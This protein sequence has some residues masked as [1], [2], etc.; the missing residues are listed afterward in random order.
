MY[1]P[2]LLFRGLSNHQYDL[3]PGLDRYPSPTW[4]N[5]LQTVEKD[6]VQT[7]QQKYPLL[8]PDTD[9]PVI[10]LAKLQHYGI[11]TRMMDVTENALV[12]LY[13]ACRRNTQMDG[14][15]IAFSGVLRSAYDPT[16]NIVADTYR[17]TGNAYT[18]VKNYRFRAL[19]RPYSTRLLY[20]NWENSSQQVIKD[21]ANMLKSPIFIEAG[22][23]CERQKNQNGKFIL[24][25]SRIHH[26]QFVMDDLIKLD[27]KSK[28]I[29]KT[30]RIP[31]ECKNLFLS[32]LKRF[33]I[34][35]DFLFCDNIDEVCK[36]IVD[37]QKERYPTAF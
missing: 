9:Y 2:K 16:A 17:L 12:A 18:E 28:Y 3:T 24:F 5:S 20:P 30:I 10:L 33:G 32:Q 31:S 8:F 22:T 29:V 15:V 34:T 7:A 1:P 21:F 36:C 19:S 25:P 23:V 6:L 11:P 13:F 35:D 14:E 26:N 37:G 4:L 27:K